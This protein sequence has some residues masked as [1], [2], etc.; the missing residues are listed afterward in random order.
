M[1]RIYQTR[2][3]IDPNIIQYVGNRADQNLAYA[4]KQTE[5]NANAVAE[6]LKP[7][8]GLADAGVRAYNTRDLID[9]NRPDPFLN[10]ARNEYIWTGNTQP[11]QNWQNNQLQMW[12]TLKNAELQQASQKWHSD[13]QDREKQAGWER[14]RQQAENMLSYIETALSKDPNNEELKR[15]KAQSISDA[16][17]YR[18]KLGM[19]TIETIN[20]QNTPEQQVGEQTVTT[21][22][23]KSPYEG[24]SNDDLVKLINDE[25]DPK[26]EWTNE[27]EA[28]AN[29]LLSH[30]KEPTLKNHMETEIRKKGKT[31]ERKAEEWNNQV[32]A[33]ND[34]IAHP[35]L[36]ENG[37]PIIPK[38][39]E[40]Y[41]KANPAQGGWQVI[42]DGEW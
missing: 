27:R 33:M 17:F 23:E 16:N 30:I 4:N 28:K 2:N 38:K 22:V 15:Q 34:Y 42:K 35:K 19:S 10:A 37:V 26:L 40:K 13:V 29:E 25:I 32:R 6:M 36:D 1:A 20:S 8:G 21:S 24:L 9:E 31:K 14:G 5:R 39:Y 41:M 11:I 3:L 12:N 18:T 7:L